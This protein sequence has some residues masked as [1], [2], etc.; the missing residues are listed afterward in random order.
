M[1]FQQKLNPHNG[2]YLEL[3]ADA[4]N[5]KVGLKYIEVSTVQEN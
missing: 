5:E 4:S 3:Y 1:I 2:L